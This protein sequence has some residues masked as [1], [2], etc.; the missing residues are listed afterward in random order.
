MV[1]LVMN[2]KKRVVTICYVVV[3]VLPYDIVHLMWMGS[4]PVATAKTL[5]QADPVTYSGSTKA[6]MHLWKM[7]GPRGLF[8][9]LVPAVLGSNVA[10][11]LYFEGYEVC[12]D[13]AAAN[14]TTHCLPTE[15]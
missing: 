15:V 8:V 10:S 9:G 5:R 11:T 14:F 4:I 13:A 3:L 6:L 7:Y 1:S 12:A 2:N